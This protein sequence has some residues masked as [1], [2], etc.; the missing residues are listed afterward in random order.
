MN[1]YVY[2]NVNQLF[3]PLS[4]R[5]FWL[6]SLSGDGKIQLEALKIS[7]SI[8]TFLAIPNNHQFNFI[9]TYNYEFQKITCNQI[10]ICRLGR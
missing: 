8:S 6:R 3:Q 7:T 1:Y 4:N 10:A 2:I 9:M 5:Y